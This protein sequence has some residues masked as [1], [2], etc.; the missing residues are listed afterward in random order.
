MEHARATR[1]PS[2]ER[3]C[4]WWPCRCSPSSRAAPRRGE[5][6]SHCSCSRGAGVHHRRRRGG[7]RR[8]DRRRAGSLVYRAATVY[9]RTRAGDHWLRSGGPPTVAGK[10]S[11]GPIRGWVSASF[12]KSPRWRQGARS[13][14]L[15]GRPPSSRG[16]VERWF[17]EGDI[18]LRG[19]GEYRPDAGVQYLLRSRFRPADAASDRYVAGYLLTSLL[20]LDAHDPVRGHGALRVELEDPANLSEMLTPRL[21][22]RGLS[23]VAR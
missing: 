13:S 12:E 3:L 4:C 9:M 16:A 2:P 11:T 23:A 22:G 21:F 10:V 14:R 19:C 20:R 7:A 15:G 18:Q 17:E 1:R 8:P 5:W 6:R